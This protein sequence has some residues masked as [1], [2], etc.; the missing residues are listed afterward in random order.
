MRSKTPTI[1]DADIIA[2]RG[3]PLQDVAE[4]GRV[5]LV[6]KDGAVFKDE[7]AAR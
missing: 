1:L 6:M 7:L 4:L 5:G 2:V 3:D